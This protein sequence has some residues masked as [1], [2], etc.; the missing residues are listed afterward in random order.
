MNIINIKRYLLMS[1]K[2]SFIGKG[3]YGCVV[4]PGITDENTIET[5]G[6]TISKLFINSE[7]YME[8]ILNYE[9]VYNIIAEN[10]KNNKKEIINF[11][12]NYT[13]KILGYSKIN[14]N[15]QKI[16]FNEE[17][18]KKYPKFLTVPQNEFIYQLKYING[19]I[20][21]EDLFSN[22][23]TGFQESINLIEFL[24][25]FYGVIIFLNLLSE[26]NHLHGDIKF[27]NILF[28]IDPK[29]NKYF[30]RVIDFGFVQ[31]FEEIYTYKSMKFLKKHLLYP[32][33]YIF[34]SNYFINP[35]IKE[36][37]YIYPFFIS[38]Y[39]DDLNEILKN[40]YIEK[41]IK[42]AFLSFY[43][44][45][46]KDYKDNKETFAKLG[47]LFNYVRSTNLMKYSEFDSS[48]I[49]TEKKES[50]KMLNN[51]INSFEKNIKESIDVYLLG[52][53]FLILLLKI[54][55]SNINYE[56]FNEGENY[57]KI[58]EI[59]N[60]IYKMIKP[61]PFERITMKEVLN[62]YKAIIDKF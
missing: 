15:E 47:E 60:L 53:S 59:L 14:K 4:A 39:I 61:N 43:N 32:P 13:T 34:I 50:N 31:N 48:E 11:I 18:L 37:K 41:P 9:I 22:K 51:Y 62:E 21:L 2:L 52:V 33:E 8:E 44:N 1:L 23:Y 57:N 46:Q 19:G 29:T 3:T 24:K 55:N 16:L 7:D 35:E 28:E 58:Q 25:S 26:H 36:V 10:F 49:I 27:D 56:Y 6:K 5:D 38:F 17:I 20:S 40:K 42:I 54:F 45:F 12:H 30:I